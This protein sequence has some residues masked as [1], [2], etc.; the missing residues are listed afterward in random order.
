MRYKPD[1]AEEIHYS[2]VSAVVYVFESGG[3]PGAMGFSGRCQKPDFHYRFHTIE[4]RETHIADWLTRL[5]EV[6]EEKARQRAVRRAFQHDLQVG[7]VLYSS[8]G[9]DQTN[10]DFYQVTRLKGKTQVVVREIESVK[11]Y[12]DGY[13]QGHAAASKDAFA[14]SE[15]TRRVQLGNR[16]CIN[17]V[18]HA[19]VWDGKPKQFSSYA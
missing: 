11:T 15:L 5:R 17:S 9:Y 4:K 12:D 19:W 18:E 16:V 2:D 10:V 14:G 7:D 8:W 6:A 3:K 13:M 1:N